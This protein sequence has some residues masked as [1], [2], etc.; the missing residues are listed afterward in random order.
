METVWRKIASVESSVWAT[1]RFLGWKTSGKL[2][3]PGLLWHYRCGKDKQPSSTEE[4]FH[5]SATGWQLDFIKI[6]KH[7]KLAPKFKQWNYPTQFGRH[8][9]AKATH[10]ILKAGGKPALWLEYLQHG[11][12]LGERGNLCNQL[13]KERK[14]WNSR[15]H[16]LSEIQHTA[17]AI[18]FY[19][20]RK[21]GFLQCCHEGQI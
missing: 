16:V 12:N 1:A 13:S 2:D 4:C 3:A 6:P 8:H 21:M 7:K 17:V 10:C 20:V 19:E 11:I 15:F 5:S 18:G 9:Q 14:G